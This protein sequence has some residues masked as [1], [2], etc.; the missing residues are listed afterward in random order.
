[1]FT[2]LKQDDYSFFLLHHHLD[3]KHSG[4]LREVVIRHANHRENRLKMLL[5]VQR[6]MDGRVAFLDNLL[7]AV[8]TIEAKRVVAAPAPIV[9][10]ESQVSD[11]HAMLST[12]TLYDKQNQNWVR[13]EATCLSD[14]TGRPVVFEMCS[15]YAP[16]AMVL[17]IGCGEG[18]CSQTC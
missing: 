5:A 7:S 10:I 17:D 6:V 3:E 9:A 13:K 12:S 11:N 1:L 16:D 15:K 14:F 2:N 4:K 18:Y 8:N